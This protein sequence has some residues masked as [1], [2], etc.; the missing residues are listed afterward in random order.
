VLATVGHVTSR[1][2]GNPGGARTATLAAPGIWERAPRPG[3]GHAASARDRRPRGAPPLAAQIAPVQIIGGAHGHAGHS[4]PA[5]Y[6]RIGHPGLP[7]SF[8]TPAGAPPRHRRS[9]AGQASP[10]RPA[11]LFLAGVA[12]GAAHAAQSCDPAT[13]KLQTDKRGAR[14][15][16]KKTEAKEQR[17]LAPTVE[18]FRAHYPI[19]TAASSNPD[20]TCHMRVSTRTSIWR[21]WP[22]RRPER[23]R[24]D[25]PSRDSGECDPG[26]A[27]CNAP[28][29]VVGAV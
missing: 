10:P 11:G 8:H 18:I 9:R 17:D 14:G 28:G 2:S 25:K 4:V 29:T 12:L 15:A 23:R 27:R 16:R 22:L 24:Q 3:P 7:D 13:Q 1:C 26:A 20:H 5:L 21:G 19:P 6:D